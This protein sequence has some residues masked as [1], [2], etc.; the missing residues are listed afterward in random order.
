MGFLAF[1]HPVSEQL[2]ALERPQQSMLCTCE[3]SVSIGP[4]CTLQFWDALNASS[5][6]EVKQV[7]CRD[8]Q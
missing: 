1:I 2:S 4:G 8:T 3:T 7:Q 5:Q 6:T